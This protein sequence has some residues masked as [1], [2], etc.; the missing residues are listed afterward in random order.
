MQVEYAIYLSSE[1]IGVN[2][3]QSGTLTAL[4]NTSILSTLIE[5]F[6]HS[7][8]LI[9][10]RMTPVILVISHCVNSAALLAWRKFRPKMKRASGE[11]SSVSLDLF[12]NQ[13]YV[14]WL[15]F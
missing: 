11:I 10:P 15:F 6:P 8:L 4:A 12:I 14:I 1:V 5:T 13:F 2:N 9:Y 7:T 3:F